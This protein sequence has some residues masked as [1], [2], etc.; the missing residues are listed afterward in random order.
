MFFLGMSW[1]SAVNSVPTIVLSM[2]EG[3]GIRVA[4]PNGFSKMNWYLKGF[5]R[6]IMLELFS[7]WSIREHYFHYYK[8]QLQTPTPVMH[9]L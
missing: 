5:T 9:R 7:S 6:P 8:F 3:F 2:D 1:V 4:I